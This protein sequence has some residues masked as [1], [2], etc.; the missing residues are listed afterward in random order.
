[1]DTNKLIKTRGLVIFQNRYKESSKIIN[2]LTR[3]RGKI[4][5]FVSGAMIPTRGLMLVTEKFVESDFTLRLNKNSYYI[6]KAKIIDSNLSLGQDPKR[7]IIGDLICE[8]VDLTMLENQ[9]DTTVYDLVIKTFEY[10]QDLS[11]DP[12]LINLAFMIKYI[13]HIGFRPRLELCSSCETRNFSNIYFSK[14][15]GGIVCDNCLNNFDDCVKL[16]KSTYEALIKLLFSKY[17]D[18]YAFDFDEK[19]MKD[20]HRLIYGYLTYNIEIDGLKSQIR[21]D[22]FF[23]I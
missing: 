21:Y 10:L 14:E 23:G 1:M 12:D 15:S 22:K 18:F 5:V 2:I 20:L 13:S 17:E 8:I 19:T 4:N 3:D 7:V 9:I 6:E 11:L 16:N